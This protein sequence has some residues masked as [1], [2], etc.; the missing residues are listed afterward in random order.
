MTIDATGAPTA[1][2][3]AFT[4]QGSAGTPQSSFNVNNLKSSDAFGKLATWLFDYP[5]CQWWMRFLR[6]FWPVSTNRCLNWAAVTRFDDVQ[7]VLTQDKVFE[8]PFGPRMIE[9]NAGGPNFILGMEDGAEY[10]RN[11]RQIMQAFRSDDAPTIVAPQASRFSKDLIDE[12]NG[13]IDAVEG[14]ITRVSTMICEDYFGIGITDKKNF[15]NWTIAMSKYL[16]GDLTNDPCIRVTGLAG[17]ECVRAVIDNSIRNAR[18]DPDNGKRKTV[19]ARLIEMQ[20]GDP[21]A[22]PDDV[23]RAHFLGM[24]TGFIPTNATAGGHM[25][26]MLLRRPDFMKRARAAALDGDDDLLMR[27]LF[28][29]MR[30]KPLNPGPVRVCKQDYTFARGGFMAWRPQTIRQGMKVVAST[31]SAMFDQRKVTRPHEFDTD[32]PAYNYML[33]GYGQHWCAGVFIA[34]AQITQTF[35]ALLVKNNVRRAC[36]RAGK[37][38]QLGGIP[39]HLRVKFDK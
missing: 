14:L 22:L 24:I 16:F 27:C 28:E 20:R 1:S 39:V 31:Q 25:L 8:V 29:A 9:L 3:P 2:G 34:K 35:K 21:A 15:A 11:L 10:R 30:F 18:A 13:E 38:E 12:S 32:R 26:E 37:L 17:A 6:W 4:L 33:L 36:G 5:Q 7:E 23:I 19:L